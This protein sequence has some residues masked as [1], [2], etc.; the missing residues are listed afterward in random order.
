MDMAFPWPTTQ[1]E[2]LAWTA[3]AVTVFFGL[4]LLVAPRLSLRA[5]R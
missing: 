2:W 4:V 1:G 3:A 5:F